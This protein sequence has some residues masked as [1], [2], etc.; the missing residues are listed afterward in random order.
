M[1]SFFWYGQ[2]VLFVV[3]LSSW[4]ILTYE[5]IVFTYLC[6]MNHREFRHLF[7]AIEFQNSENLA[8]LYFILFNALYGAI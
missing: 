7:F 2:I 1:T 3:N 8:E 5:A 6:K 4:M